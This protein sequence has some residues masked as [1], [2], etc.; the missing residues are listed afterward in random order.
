MGRRLACWMVVL[1]AGCSASTGGGDDDGR[2]AGSN[3]RDAGARDAAI[4]DSAPD[5][6]AASPPIGPFNVILIL[7]D[8]QRA[9]AIACM[10]KLQEHLVRRGVTFSDFF[11]STPLC[12]PSRSTELTGLYAHNHGVR[13]N[14]DEEVELYDLERDPIELDNL[15]R[16]PDTRIEE[17]GYEPAEIE[18]TIEDLRGRLARLSEE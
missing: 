6:D 9:D 14:G 8:D 4:R 10:P 13:S 2:D 15:A 3:R 5:Q 17:L 16:L 7:T 11:V 1:V 12:C 18:A